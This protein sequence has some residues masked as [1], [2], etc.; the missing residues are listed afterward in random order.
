MPCG[1]LLFSDRGE[2]FGYEKGAF[3]GAMASKQGRIDL[4]HGG[5]LFL[6]EV[7][8]MSPKTQ[9][10]FIRVL[11]EEEFR[12]LGGTKLIRGDIR[13]IAASNRDLEARVRA[14][15]FPRTSTTGS[16]L[17]HLPPA[18]AGGEGGHPVAGRDLS[19]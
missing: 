12:R 1:L 15:Q 7:G 5:T 10:D 4:A 18:V 19:G 8:E 2:L 11:Q 13:V 14:G 9:V 17:P 3:T 6:D 16:T